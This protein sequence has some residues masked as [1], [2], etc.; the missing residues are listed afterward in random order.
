MPGLRSLLN[1]PLLP[2][3][4]FDQPALDR[5]PLEASLRGLATGIYGGLREMSSPAELALGVMPVGGA[6][7]R[8]LKGLSP[9][10]RALKRLP[11]VPAYKPP[12]G[13]DFDDTWKMFQKYAGK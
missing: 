2:E 11:P 13:L 4:E 6:A 9:I 5:S 10:A 3:A 1:D 12:A 8:G 7:V